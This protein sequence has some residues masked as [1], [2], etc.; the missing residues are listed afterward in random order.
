MYNIDSQNLMN[1]T[2]SLFLV[3]IHRFESLLICIQGLL[4]RYVWHATGRAV[5]IANK[6]LY[7]RCYPYPARIRYVTGN[8]ANVE[9]VQTDVT[10]Y[11]VDCLRFRTYLRHSWWLV[12]Y[13]INEGL[14]VVPGVPHQINETNPVAQAPNHHRLSRTVACP[15]PS[16]IV[17]RQRRSR[18][19]RQRVDDPGALR[20]ELPALGRRWRG[21]A[22]AAA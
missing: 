19:S 1:P 14:Q 5:N 22:A 11:F 13:D 16:P 9:T 10:M 21:S 7:R 15:F 18:D 8:Y 6:C 20:R 12:S 4:I 3:L 17:G 2:I